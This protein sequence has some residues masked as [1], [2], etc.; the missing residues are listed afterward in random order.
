MFGSS[1]WG[2]LQSEARASAPRTRRGGNVIIQKQ[3]PTKPEAMPDEI[4]GEEL[5]GSGFENELSESDFVEPKS[6]SEREER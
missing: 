3:I 2:S 4:G 6:F 1:I 5:A